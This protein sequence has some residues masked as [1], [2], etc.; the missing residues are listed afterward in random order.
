VIYAVRLAMGFVTFLGPL[1]VLSFSHSL[2]AVVAVLVAGRFLGACIYLALCIR[3]L[4]MLKAGLTLDRRIGAELIR[5]GSWIMVSN[6]LGPIMVYADRF[7]IGGVLSV[8]VVA[9]YTTPFEVVTKIWIVPTAFTAVLF[10]AFAAL[11][12]TRPEQLVRT[13]A[14]S[15]RSMLAL[16]FPVV[17]I[18]ILFAGNG[19]NLWLGHAFMQNSTAVF[20]WLAIGVFINSMAQVPYSLLQAVNRPDI[21]GKI[22]TLELPIYLAVLW[23]GIHALGLVGAAIAWASRLAIEAIVLFAIA[24]RTAVPRALSKHFWALVLAAVGLLYLATRDLTLPAKLLFLGMVITLY[25]GILWRVARK[26][27]MAF[28]TPFFGRVAQR[29]C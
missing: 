8:G 18:A 3:A 5:F 10:P 2:V 21:T 23:I 28:M 20:Q 25:L 19:L 11:F 27:A 15:V 13:Y 1:A 12:L 4:P 24:N 9:Y 14:L 17:F 6:L 26:G 22:H 29:D 7:V 16:L